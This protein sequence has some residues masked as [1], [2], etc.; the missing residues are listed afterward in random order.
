MI[1]DYGAEEAQKQRI[2]DVR[3][4]LKRKGLKGLKFSEIKPNRWYQYYDPEY[5]VDAQR[6][7]VYAVDPVDREVKLDHGEKRPGQYTESWWIV[8]EKDDSDITDEMEILRYV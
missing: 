7:F 6:V 3:E 2:K 5:E 1:A 8:Y 4:E